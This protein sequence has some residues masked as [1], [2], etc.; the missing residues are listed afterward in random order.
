VVKAAA[1]SLVTNYRESYG[2]FAFSS[3]DPQ[4]HSGSGQDWR[5]EPRAACSWQP[6]D[7]PRLADAAQ[8]DL[9]FGDAARGLLDYR[10]G[11]VSK[12]IEAICR[13]AIIVGPDRVTSR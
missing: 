1:I 6:L 9:R 3:L 10:V 5:R 2:L 7:P 11:V 4:G 8:I 12:A 13:V